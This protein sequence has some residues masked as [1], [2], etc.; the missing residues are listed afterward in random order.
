MNNGR[1][2]NDY[3][4]IVETIFLFSSCV[5]VKNL[6]IYSEFLDLNGEFYSE[7]SNIWCVEMPVFMLWKAG[8]GEGSP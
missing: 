3:L 7:N 2:G 5:R 8:K 4:V 6:L 1:E